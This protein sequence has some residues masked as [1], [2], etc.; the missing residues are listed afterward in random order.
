MDLGDHEN[1]TSPQKRA[2][3]LRIISVGITIP[4]PKGDV[5]GTILMYDNE[6]AER[7]RT[8]LKP[9]PMN[10]LPVPLSMP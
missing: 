8:R 7:S 2:S 3:S 1:W 5:D 9:H 10:V 4:Q 6:S